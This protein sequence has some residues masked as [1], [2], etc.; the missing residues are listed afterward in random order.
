MS[1]LIIVSEAKLLVINKKKT[2]IYL[3]IRILH[4]T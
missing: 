2:V 3:K 4:V 1:L